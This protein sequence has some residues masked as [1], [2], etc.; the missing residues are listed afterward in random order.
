M[1]ALF[2]LDVPHDR[3]R[4]DVDARL[5]LEWLDEPIE[6]EL[7]STTGNSVSTVR[8]FGPEHIAKWQKLH[9]LFAFY[10][11][12]G[13]TLRYCYY[14]SP[15]D[16]SDWIAEKEKYI[17]PAFPICPSCIYV[18]PANG[19]SWGNPWRIATSGTDNRKCPFAAGNARARCL[20]GA[21]PFGHT[22][23]AEKVR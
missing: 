17:R 14:A 19:Q 8:D 1:I 4:S 5:D 22:S 23:R 16:M 10:E 7:K 6:F 21:T 2:N 11:S 3:A 13:T 9:W 12:D 18:A 15:A 20:V